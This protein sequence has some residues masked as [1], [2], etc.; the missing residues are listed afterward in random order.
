MRAPPARRQRR[1]VGV[2]TGAPESVPAAIRPRSDRQ[3]GLQMAKGRASLGHVRVTCASRA[4]APSAARRVDQA[5]DVCMHVRPARGACRSNTI[6]TPRQPCRTCASQ[7]LPRAHR[8]S[9]LCLRAAR[10]CTRATPLPVRALQLRSA[11]GVQVVP[12]QPWAPASPRV[13]QRSGGRRSR[14]SC[15]VFWPSRIKLQNW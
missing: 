4:W 5:P 12:A 1:P 10:V 14:R 8:S 2:G 13:S 6:A 3:P 9:F 7:W 11:V 15:K